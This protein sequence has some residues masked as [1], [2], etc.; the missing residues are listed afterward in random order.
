[1]LSSSVDGT[2]KIWN[3]DTF[4]QEYSKHSGLVDV[5][6]GYRI[7]G[8]TRVAIGGYSPCDIKILDINTR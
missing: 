7:P 6:C 5:N 1:M 3:L 8:T 2:T 4:T